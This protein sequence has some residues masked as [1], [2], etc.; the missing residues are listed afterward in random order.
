MWKALQLTYNM[1]VE[2]KMLPTVPGFGTFFY[3]AC[4][5][6][7]FHTAT[8]E[9]MNLRSSYWK[10]LHGLSGGRVAGMGRECMD[11]WGL[12][13]SKQLRDKLALTNTSLKVEF[14]F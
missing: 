11:C 9:P 6:L 1:G 7:L 5:A 8:L 4:T 3:C 14:T 12:A 10:F 13:T 2:R